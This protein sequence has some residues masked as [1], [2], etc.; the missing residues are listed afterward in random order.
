MS[1]SK[2]FSLSDGST[3]LPSRQT[4][5]TP[6]GDIAYLEAGEGPA[7]LF[8]HG[9]FLNADLWR[10]QLA[11]VA[12]LRRCIAVDLLAHGQS[13]CPPSGQELT[14]SMQADMVLALLDAL[15]IDSADLVGND[16]GGSV[17]QLVVARAPQ[18]V[19]TLTLTNCEA[20]DNFPP[21]AFAS[22]HQMAREG[23]LAAVL[24]ALAADP[25]LGRGAMASGLEHPERISDET[26]LG[27]F[28][29]FAS[30]ERAEAVQGYVAGMDSSVTVAIR[31]DLAHFLHPTLIVWGT[32][33]EFF[34]VRWAR[35]LA[36]TI[37]GTVRCVEVQ[38]AKLLFPAE[39]PET[40]N[41]EL[42]NLWAADDPGKNG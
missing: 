5:R 36:A 33:D 20:H 22:V 29:P 18:R 15:G 19:R 4:V 17:A 31:D 24:A 6:F 28:A 8:V 39:R 32:A 9:V 41:R 37:P 16:S 21:A 11:G 7:A 12:D 30:A 1:L 23:T 3:A 26:L 2:T 42:R 14:L 25:D 27:Y 34:P 13:P 35:W 38:G 40:L 10:H